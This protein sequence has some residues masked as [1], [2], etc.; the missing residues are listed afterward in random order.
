MFLTQLLTKD[1]E[2]LY[3]LLE[4]SL[5]QYLVQQSDKDGRGRR[6]KKNTEN[7]QDHEQ[8]ETQMASTSAGHRDNQKLLG[9][10][11]LLLVHI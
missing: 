6:E 10:N 11:N 8:A 3:N 2:K 9:N 7:P 5:F 4:I 1:G